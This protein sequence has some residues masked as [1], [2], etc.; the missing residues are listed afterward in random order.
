MC[1][2]LFAN[3]NISDESII[4]SEKNVSRRGPDHKN[5]LKKDNFTYVHYLLHITGEMSPQPLQNKTGELTLLYNGEIYNYKELGTYK[6]DGYSI[7]DAY[8]S[9]GI[10]GLR[11]LDGEFSGLIYDAKINK[12][13]IFR[14]VFGTKPIHVGV[15]D[16]KIVISSYISQLKSLGYDNILI[17]N[18]NNIFVIDMNTL[19]TEVEEYKKFNLNQYRKNYDLWLDAFINSIKK[20]TSNKKVNYFIGLSSG[21]DSGL[22]AAVM[23]QLEIDF[24]SYSIKAAEDL[25]VM[26]KRSKL[27]KNNE[28]FHLSK[29]EFETQKNFLLNNCEDYI[30]PPRHNRPNGYGVLRDKGAIGT[31]VICEKAIKDKCKVYISGQGSDEIISDYGYN[32][33]MAPGF[34]HGTF[35]GKFP[36]KLESIFPWENFYSGTQ[37]EF[38]SKD[39]NVGG[40]YG[41]ETRYPFLDYNL[42]QEFLNLHED[43][44]NKAYKSPIAYALNKLNFPFSNSGLNSKVGFRANA[45]FRK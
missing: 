36:S 12:T 27:V 21:Y 37:V 14:D 15:K 41:I 16:K 18:P 44:K 29:Q 8:E 26:Y 11:K 24:K 22:I 28:I 19:G 32:G 33:R 17:P 13:I 45:N 30:T 34:L 5:V 42:V 43:L 2:F 7:L 1:G 20:R 10:D 31:G 6:S 23:T 39:E 9:E 25:D 40:T 35:A 38:I 3:Y 4:K